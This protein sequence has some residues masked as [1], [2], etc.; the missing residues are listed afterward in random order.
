MS[1]LTAQLGVAVVALVVGWI[2]LWPARR[3]LGAATYHLVA[4]PVGL[5]AWPLAGAFSTAAGREF[6]ALTVL[7][8]AA[9][10]IATAWVTERLT[11]D[12][13][14]TPTGRV[15]PA[16]FAVTLGALVSV[17]ALY[18]LTRMTAVNNDGAV[19][20]W[21][22][23]VV[24]SRT[25]E[26]T[27]AVMAIRA[28]LLP[29]T[30]AGHV[31]FGSD[32]AYAIYPLFAVNLIAYAVASLLGGPLATASSRVRWV[33]T[34]A[35]ALFLITDPTF[36]FHA[37]YVHCH[38]ITA[39][40]LLIALS[41]L[42]RGLP[43]ATGQGGPARSN[44]HILVA[45]VCTAGI[46]LA[47]PDGIAYALVVIVIAIAALTRDGF[48]REAT[49]AFFGPA[50]FITFAT[51]AA[52]YA[53]LGFWRSGKLSG[54]RA[55]V[56]LVALA[57][58]ALGPWLIA[59]LDRMLPFK[60]AGDRFL[61]L[62]A[63]GAFA[64]LGAAFVLRPE[65]AKLAML[66]AGT[67]LFAGTGGYGYLWY[68]VVALLVMSLVTGDALRGVSWTEPAFLAIVLNALAIA[69]VHAVSHP[70][71]IGA[72]DTLNR[73]VFHLVPLVAWYAAAIASRIF[74]PQTQAPSSE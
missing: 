9:I 44:A 1:A 70:G 67:N 4:M 45:G 10:L 5:L 60:I 2:A 14:D 74:T 30:N 38:M 27:K 8:G 7:A 69:I 25:G 68:A 3:G 56:V 43:P 24:L 64:L 31:L 62:A 33:V 35:V 61:R 55:A 46:A 40:Y 19:S 66:N 50:L 57:A 28:P 71:R 63:V 37:V 13:T 18:T 48:D 12:E 36:L 22:L 72:G 29:S 26:F 23:G 39:L 54:R 34:G 41:E 53:R 15:G 52:A 51:Y 58:S 16:G 21:P 20:F 59:R 17:G 32:W 42:W 65:T 6:D 73:M 49:L 11:R 47:R